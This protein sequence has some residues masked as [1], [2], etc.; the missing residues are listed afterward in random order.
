MRRMKV[1]EIAKQFDLESKDV[2]KLLNDMGEFVRSAS[3]TVEPPVLRRLAERLDITRSGGRRSSNVPAAVTHPDGAKLPARRTDK[4][5]SSGN[6]PFASP[7]VDGPLPNRTT[8]RPITDDA[9][10]SGYPIPSAV[11]STVER[12]LEEVAIA[13][14]LGVTNQYLGR[15]RRGIPRAPKIRPRRDD[16]WARSWITDD[17]RLEWIHAGV[18]VAD[19]AARYLEAG[20]NPSDVMRFITRQHMSIDGAVYAKTH[21]LSDEELDH[22]VGESTVRQFVSNGATMEEVRQIERD[23]A[24]SDRYRYRGR[25]PSA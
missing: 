19:D 4:R 6:N 9:K 13:E 7:R 12:D 20:L 8:R 24:R 5:S 23:L 14:Y 21:G 22:V 1:H 2:L 25:R 17:E 18:L 10:I 16:S 3:S 15:G 11:G